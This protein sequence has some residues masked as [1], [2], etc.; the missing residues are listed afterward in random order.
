[1]HKVLI[2]TQNSLQCCKVRSGIRTHFECL[3]F[4]R[5]GSTQ[6]R[7]GITFGTYLAF[8]IKAQNMPS[9]S[10]IICTVR[11]KGNINS[12]AAFCLYLQCLVSTRWN[13]SSFNPKSSLSMAATHFSSALPLLHKDFVLISQCPA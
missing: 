2:L 8:F 10:A 1:M 12:C 4:S 7:A 11:E 6:S 3:L 9:S 13:C 5:S